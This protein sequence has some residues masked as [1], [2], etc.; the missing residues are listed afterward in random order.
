MELLTLNGRTA[1]VVLFLLIM[2]FASAPLAV[3]CDCDDF[4]VEDASKTSASIFIGEVIS[5]SD[6][7][8]A[9]IGSK[10]EKVY[11]TTFLVWER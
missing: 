4:A 1:L 2:I 7:R 11:L 3:A 9:F 8:E 6:P 5:V 10:T